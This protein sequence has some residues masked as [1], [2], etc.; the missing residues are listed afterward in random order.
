MH[1]SSQTRGESYLARVKDAVC[2]AILVSALL[3]TGPLQA[4]VDINEDGWRQVATTTAG[5]IYHREITGSPIPWIMIVATF[6]ATPARVHKVVVDYDHFPEFIPNVLQS[7]VVANEGND[8]WVYHHLTFPGPISDR[9]YV[10]R[11]TDL[12]NR[13]AQQYYRVDWQLDNRPLPEI[14]FPAGIRPDAFSGFWEL[15]AAGDSNTT[16][17]HYAVHSEPGGFIPGWL[18]TGMTERYVQ[19]VVEAVRN[20]LSAGE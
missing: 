17:A 3:L 8:Q 9:V 16:V 4:G 7:R 18:V 15:K 11:S 10:I 20:R 6:E 14:D 12:E 19:Q 1:Y 5:Q 2:F 13:P